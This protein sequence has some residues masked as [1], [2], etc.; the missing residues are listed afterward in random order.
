MKAI[1]KN[2]V[3][4]RCNSKVLTVL[5]LMNKPHKVPGEVYQRTMPKAE[6]LCEKMNNWLE[7]KLEGQM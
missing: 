4:A 6:E 2:W 3:T 1:D 7:R 5:Y